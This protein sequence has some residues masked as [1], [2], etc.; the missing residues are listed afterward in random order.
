MN[1]R[2]DFEPLADLLTLVCIAISCA[3]LWVLPEVLR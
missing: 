3:V 1:R 2:D